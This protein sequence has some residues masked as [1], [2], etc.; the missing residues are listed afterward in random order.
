MWQD[1]GTEDKESVIMWTENEESV[2]MWTESEESVI[3]WTEN[4][5]SVIMRQDRWTAKSVQIFT[6]EIWVLF[7]LVVYSLEQAG[8][9]YRLECYTLPME[10]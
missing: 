6:I 4:K 2:I 8:A 10:C 7:S 1:S 3:M 9:I 5:E